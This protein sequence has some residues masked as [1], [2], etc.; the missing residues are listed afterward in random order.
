M[1]KTL[2]FIALATIA[3]ANIAVAR[4][5]YTKINVVANPA[6]LNGTYEIDQLLIKKDGVTLLDS[7]DDDGRK[8]PID[9]SRGDMTINLSGDALTVTYKMQIEGKIFES[10]ASLKQYEYM[11][12]TVS[13]QLPAGASLAERLETVGVMIYDKDELFL[14]LVLEDG[15]TAIFRVEKELDEIKE[16]KN[17]K[18]KFL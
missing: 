10:D 2:L 1:K 18:Y 16:L 4:D 13:I 9:D 11:Y 15:N 12:D 7:E 14:K 8:A 5:H 17:S 6:S 3:T